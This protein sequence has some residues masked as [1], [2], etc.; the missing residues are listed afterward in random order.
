MM[1]ERLA[2]PGFAPGFPTYACSCAGKS[3]SDKRGLVFGI[4][5]MF[6]RMGSLRKTIHV[7]K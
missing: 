3:H 5:F 2:V 7:G 6:K 1:P 4:A